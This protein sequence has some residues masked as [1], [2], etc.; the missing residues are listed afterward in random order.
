MAADDEWQ[1]DQD[2]GESSPQVVEPSPPSTVAT[3]PKE[4]TEE[5]LHKLALQL[6]TVLASYVE[7]A[8]QD[9]AQ[10]T[11]ETKREPVGGFAFYLSLAALTVATPVLLIL[12]ASLFTAE[13][14]YSSCSF[15]GGIL[16][17]L[18]VTKLL[19]RRHFSVLVHEFKH[20]IISNLVGNKPKKM[21]IDADSGYF[22]YSYTKKTSHFNAFISLAPYIVPLF[23]FVSA[24]IALAAARSNHSL[25]AAILGI[26]YGTDLLLNIRDI[27]SVQTDIT[28]IRGGYNVGLFYIFVWN[29][30][31]L[32]V[33][34]CWVFQSGSGFLMLLHE[35]SYVFV[36][37][38]QYLLNSGGSGS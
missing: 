19:I 26:G 31:I 25:A 10:E 5:D 11:S 23:S 30:A 38:H 35:V 36:V 7:T 8:E 13:S 32:A 2:R 16:I 27:S 33:L 24:L 15:L 9:S 6:E 17:G 4:L 3:D 21:K 20:Q 12:A 28:D 18:A 37:L 14:L 22:E 29:G 34:L 1:G